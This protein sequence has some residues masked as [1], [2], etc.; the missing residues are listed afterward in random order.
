MFCGDNNKK[1]DLDGSDSVLSS[2][3]LFGGSASSENLIKIRNNHVYFYEEVSKKN[4]LKLIDEIHTLESNLKSKVDNIE[5]DKPT[6]YL[7][8]N[9]DGGCV[10]SALSCLDTLSN[11]DVKL[12]TIAE[13]T[14]CSAATIIYLAG[15]DRWMRKH[16]YTLIH[17][18]RTF[19]GWKTHKEL[20]NELDTTNELQNMLVNLYKEYTKIPNKKIESLMSKE[21]MMDSGTCLKYE[22]CN[23]VI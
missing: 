4:V 22:F 9:S 6:I 12:V 10:Y 13:G 18:L 1:K 16:T 14:I 11:L 7:H 8:I 15:K 20:N 19:S 3:D 2:D 21:I 5:I 23:K 17:Q